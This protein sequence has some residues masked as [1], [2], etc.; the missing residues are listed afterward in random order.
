MTSFHF[1]Q[2]LPKLFIIILSVLVV[3]QLVLSATCIGLT[4]EASSKNETEQWLKESLQKYGQDTDIKAGIG[5]SYKT[6]AKKHPSV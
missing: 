1:Q 4:F 6:A 3:M 2:C 5:K